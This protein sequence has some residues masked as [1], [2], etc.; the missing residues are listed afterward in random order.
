MLNLLGWREERSC[1]NS[2][3]EN[4]LTKTSINPPLFLLLAPALDRTENKRSNCTTKFW[5]IFMSP[6]TRLKIIWI[7]F[8]SLIFVLKLVFQHHKVHFVLFEPH[9]HEIIALQSKY[10]NSSSHHVH[11]WVCIDVSQYLSTFHYK[12]CTH[13][14]HVCTL[15]SPNHD[16]L[17]CMSLSYCQSI[18]RMN[19][20][21]C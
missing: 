8:G 12:Q 11:F 1:P 3:V 9:K 17:S 13:T 14:R 4:G 5:R 2:D 21:S 7:F 6:H 19:T 16:N 20:F 10:R 15:R 18:E